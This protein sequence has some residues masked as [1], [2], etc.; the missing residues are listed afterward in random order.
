MHLPFIPES[1]PIKDLDHERL[2]PLVGDARGALATYGGLLEGI[3][4]PAVLL[5]PLINEE[6]VVSS[7]IEGTQ[8]TQYDLFQYEA[9]MEQPE[10]KGPSGW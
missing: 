5:S 3:V 2:L 7:K 8:A 1:L 6:A 9:G 10:E 4:N